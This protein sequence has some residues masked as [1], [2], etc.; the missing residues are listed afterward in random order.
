MP[1]L[2]VRKRGSAQVAQAGCGSADNHDLAGELVGRPLALAALEVL[3]Q[4]AKGHTRQLLG[5]AAPGEHQVIGVGQR[6]TEVHCHA[7]R[8]R[9][10]VPALDS[11]AQFV[12]S[13]DAIVVREKIDRAGAPE[14]LR[15]EERRYDRNARVRI[16]PWPGYQVDQRRELARA[17]ASLGF[18]AHHRIEDLHVAVPQG[19]RYEFLVAFWPDDVGLGEKDVEHDCARVL[20][21]EAIEQLTV[22]DARPRETAGDL[23]EVGEALLVDVHQHDV[24]VRSQLGRV[25][26]DH[27]VEQAVLERLHPVQEGELEREQGEHRYPYQRQAALH[28]PAMVS[29]SACRSSTLA[30]IS[31]RLMDTL[32]TFTPSGTWPA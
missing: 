8:Q 29:R 2:L 31:S 32:S 4:V 12:A 21:R 28:R 10:Q 15:Q 13:A 18:E 23:V 7:R 6:K 3:V 27:A 19:R 30:S 16:R 5:A 9:R 26:T 25:R 1:R 17:H 22:D 11:R 24:G 20:R 14:L